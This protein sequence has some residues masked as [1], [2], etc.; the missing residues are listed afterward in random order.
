MGGGGCSG[1]AGGGLAGRTG[2]G[3][4]GLGVMKVWVV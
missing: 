2:P 1:T 3:E 4:E